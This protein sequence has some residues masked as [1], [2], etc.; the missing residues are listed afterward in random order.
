VLP[1]G[2]L[3][4]VFMLINNFKN[5][6]KTRGYTVEVMRSTD[7][8]ATWSKPIVVSKIAPTEVT[9]PTTGHDVR[10]G[11]IIP[12]VGVDRS[13]GAL[14]VVWQDNQFSG[15]SAIALSKST[16]G[17]LHWTAPVVVNTHL[18]AQAFIPSVEV[19]ADG[20]VGVTYYDFRNDTATPPLD[21]DYWII[22]SH[23]GGA[24]WTENHVAGPFDMATAPDAGGYFLGDYQGLATIGSRFL[25][26]FVQANSGNTANRTDPYF[27]TAGS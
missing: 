16:D 9:D 21:T 23:D 18:D 2:T 1:N 12:E 17:G 19:A 26:F 15:Q 27:T 25:P 7:K 4:N 24:T 6:H 10:T 20:T 8:G 3:V 11:D 13:S 5:A 14:Y 22:H